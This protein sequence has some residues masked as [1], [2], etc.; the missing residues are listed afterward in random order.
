[1]I[2]VAICHDRPGALQT[3]LDNRPAHLAYLDAAK[4]VVKAA[5]AL[6]GPDD[7]PVGSMLILD[8]A[9]QGA[10]DAFLAGDPFARAGLFASVEVKPWRQSVGAPVG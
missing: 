6:L 9:D 5:G 7:K 3:R 10:A 8:C 2:F 1:M 4:D